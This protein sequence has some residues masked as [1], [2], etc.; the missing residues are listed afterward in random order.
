MFVVGNN[1][2]NKSYPMFDTRV[3]II[4]LSYLVFGVILDMIVNGINY[5]DSPFYPTKTG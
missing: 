5:T 4:F 3:N 1:M 2:I